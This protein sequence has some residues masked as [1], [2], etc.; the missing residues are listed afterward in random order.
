MDVAT[1]RPSSTNPAPPRVRK[2]A[3]AMFPSLR[4]PLSRTELEEDVEEMLSSYTEIVEKRKKMKKGA[5]TKD[6]TVRIMHNNVS[7]VLYN[8][9][10][11]E[12]GDEV[13]VK[14]VLEKRYCTGMITTITA[15]EMF[16]LQSNETYE[17]VSL[18]ALRTGKAILKVLTSSSDENED[19]Y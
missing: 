19:G 15:S 10:V 4:L 2:R 7:R 17:I 3:G 13:H 11:V 8:N 16:V 18:M 1:T 14:F 5:Q 9:L 6:A 12:E